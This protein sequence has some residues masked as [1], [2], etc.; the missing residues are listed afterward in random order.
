LSSV[1]R[2]DKRL[3][4]IFEKFKK[5]N[6]M[7]QRSRT[8]VVILVWLPSL[9]LHGRF[10]RCHL[11]RCLHDSR[12]QYSFCRH[13]SFCDGQKYTCYDALQCVWLLYLLFLVN[14]CTFLLHCNNVA[15]LVPTPYALVSVVN[16]QD[17]LQPPAVEQSHQHSVTTS[18]R[19]RNNDTS[20]DASTNFTSSFLSEDH[21][22]L[23]QQQQQQ[24]LHTVDFIE[25]SF[26]DAIQVDPDCMA[27]AATDGNNG[28]TKRIDDCWK[29]PDSTLPT[30]TTSTVHVQQR[31]PQ[32]SAS[33]TTTETC[34]ET[35]THNIEI[36][37]FLQNHTT[38]GTTTNV[39]SIT[40]EKR[41]IVDKHWGSDPDILRMR[42]K[43]QLNGLH[44]SSQYHNYQYDDIPLLTSATGQHTNQTSAIPK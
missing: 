26:F 23:P 24:T 13:W 9:C 15:I 1:C 18:N 11:I 34:L 2:N 33:A 38:R 7:K 28:N 12:R 6:K 30:S 19:R 4:W 20:G 8:Y 31:P 32:P 43:L 29:P 35:D 25:D 40:G 27:S 22:H 44:T 41:F 36:Q 42:Q 37:S 5:P 3:R 14:H 17:T 10:C 16:A 21:I 39:T